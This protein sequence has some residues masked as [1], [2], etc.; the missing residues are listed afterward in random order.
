[1]I[2]EARIKF[3]NCDSDKTLG[4]TCEEMKTC[5]L[6]NSENEAHFKEADSNDD[7]E[8]SFEELL[9]YVTKFLKFTSG[10]PEFVY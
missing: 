3:N 4:L 5:G 8:L 7:G 6:G 1:M 9:D 2:E 10:S